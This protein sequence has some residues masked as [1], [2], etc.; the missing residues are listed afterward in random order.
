MTNDD[1]RDRQFELSVQ[2]G[3]NQRYHQER[4][5]H[6]SWWDKAAK[7]V[8]GILAVIGACVTAATLVPHPH[9]IDVA[10]MVVASLAAG[11]A[12]A[13]NVVP[14]G[15]WAAHHLALLQRWTDFREDV[16]LL[17]YDLDGDPEPPVVERLKQLDAKRHRICGTEPA[18][19][20]AKLRECYND[21]CASRMPAGSA[22]AV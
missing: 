17:L 18:P 3:M 9:E 14:L 19:I 8:V 2:A 4:E 6:W 20:K 22:C 1:F 10:A 15:D 5:H 21:E 16:D 13:L 11:A 12:V 7:I